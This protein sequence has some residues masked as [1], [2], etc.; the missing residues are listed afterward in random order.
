LEQ[1]LQERMA[2][3]EQATGIDHS[4]IQAPSIFW[5]DDS[6]FCDSH[7]DQVWRVWKRT[8]IRWNK[9]CKVKIIL[10]SSGK[11]FVIDRFEEVLPQSRIAAFFR[12]KY[13]MAWV[14]PI[15]I[16]EKQL[17]LEEFKKEVL[18]AVKAKQ[19]YDRGSRIVENTME[20]LPSAE[21]YIE[22]IEALPKL[23]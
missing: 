11:R 1:A 20:K 18:R 12:E 5:T 3:S 2:M 21:T 10:D 9:Y 4:P 13:W 15:I 16:S 19:R 7:T 6:V 14:T 8:Y 22:V 23:L 17:S